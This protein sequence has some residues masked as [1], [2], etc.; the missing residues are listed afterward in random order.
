V[1]DAIQSRQAMERLNAELRESEEER[2]E[3]WPSEPRSTGGNRSRA[4][5][6]PATVS[7]NCERP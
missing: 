1:E 2:E 5:S 7:H 4:K 6:F 3:L